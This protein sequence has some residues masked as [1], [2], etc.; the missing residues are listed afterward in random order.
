MTTTNGVKLRAPE[1]YPDRERAAIATVDK[2][3]LGFVLTTAEE[4]F[5][6]LAEPDYLVEGAFR[7]GSL[8]LLG[9][10]GSSWKTWLALAL[11]ISVASGKP[12]LGRFDSKQGLA[13]V[14]D[15]ESG[16]YEL[17]RR[18]QRIAR[19]MGL[20]AVV[21]LDFCSMPDAYMGTEAFAKRVRKLAAK[22]ALIAI[23]SLRAASPGAEEND[24]S[25]RRGLDQLRTIAEST[26][27]VF[28][29]LVHA[30][31]TSMG[32][33]KPDPREML[34]GSSAI[35]DAADT[36]LVAT[37]AK[38]KPLRVEQ[39]KSRHGKAIESFD[40][41]IKD[42]P[43][44]T[45]V[46]LQASDVEADEDETPDQQFTTTCDGVMR[47][48]REH[49]GS[50]LRFI[51]AHMKGVGYRQSAAAVEHLAK[52]QRI[53]NLGTTQNQQWRVVADA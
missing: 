35:F 16:N 37:S 27:C 38:G 33:V 2:P 31:K 9:G 21:G 18:M 46:V 26:G 8:T 11:V 48:L 19:G 40:V 4:I 32:P 28:L 45:G 30:K 14:L 53:Q 1:N 29:V 20:G 41:T 44:G 25:M 13:S 10:Y 15:W 43:L 34:R 50:S 47:L 51:R 23:D 36:V 12:W 6:E 24:S 42:T 3:D 5:G 49:P 7:R 17:R 22:R 52:L 39:A